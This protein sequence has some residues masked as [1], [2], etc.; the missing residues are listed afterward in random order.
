MNDR[1][2]QEIIEEEIIKQEENQESPEIKL[3]NTRNSSHIINLISNKMNSI[4][5][6]TCATLD[7]NFGKESQSNAI[8]FFEEDSEQEMHRDCDLLNISSENIDI[9]P[10]LKNPK[11]N[12][13][14]SS[15]SPIRSSRKEVKE[16]TSDNKIKNIKISKNTCVYY[17]D[18]QESYFDKFMKKKRLISDV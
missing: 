2:E 6:A 9:K 8:Q 5:G 4:D 1:E 13:K 18:S 11:I 14:F 17:Y 15:S 10:I 3:K 12:N 7:L 16:S